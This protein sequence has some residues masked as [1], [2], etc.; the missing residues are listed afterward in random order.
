MTDAPLP[1]IR[2][3]DVF[4]VTNDDGSQ[5]IVVQDNSRIAPDPLALT[6]AGYFILAHLDGERNIADIQE[7]FTEQFGAPVEAEMVQELVKVLDQALMLDNERTQAI[8]QERVDT[9]LAG[10]VRDNRESWPS[11]DELRQELNGLLD[12]MLSV[13]GKN[14]NGLRGIVAPHLDYA[15][16][17]ECYRAAYSA[18]QSA[19]PADRYVILGTNHFGKAIGAVATRKDFLTPLGRVTTDRDFLDGLNSRV[20][21]D[22]FEHEYDHLREHSIELQV[23][24]L[25]MLYPEQ[26][27]TIVP[28]LC[29]DPDLLEHVGRSSEELD[30]LAAALRK[31]ISEHDD[32]TIVIAG[33]DLSHVGQRF[34]EPEPSSPAFLESVA[35]FDQQFLELLKNRQ[36]DLATAT[37]TMQGNPTRMC[38]LGCIYTLA[39]AIPRVNCKLLAY[40]QAVDY[41]NETHVT[42]A[43]LVYGG[44]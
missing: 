3:L 10:E 29:P 39:R 40:D 20:K 2:P 16:G 43:A 4:P 28:I 6:P 21:F 35:N 22:L 12:T 11:G 25:Q 9:F 42:C 5:S 37:V 34:G 18:L 17:Q 32:R 44:R 33:A 1:A 30:K 15:R 41:E 7:L 24:L 23:H 19:G 14:S 38:S 13:T 26:P 8:Y 27:F 36:E 31:E